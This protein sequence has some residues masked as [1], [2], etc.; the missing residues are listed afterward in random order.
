MNSQVIKIWE[1]KKNF[2]NIYLKTKGH[3]IDCFGIGTHLVTCQK[4]PAL[5]CVYKVN[6]HF[7]FPL[8]KCL[9]KNYFEKLKLVELNGRP[10]VK[11]SEDL[12]KVIFPGKK[13]VYRLYDK[14]DI[15]LVDLL[16]KH[17]EPAP[18]IGKKFLC[19]HPFIVRIDRFKL[20]IKNKIK[21]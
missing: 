8:F 6:Y 18:E 12:N 7:L 14:D 20:R 10:C 4:Q 11:L 3:S 5:G 21:L 19:R 17:D 16:C 15:S 2:L 1:I 13:N 9:Q